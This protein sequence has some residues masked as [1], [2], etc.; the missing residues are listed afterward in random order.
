LTPFLCSPVTDQILVVEA[1]LHHKTC[2][3]LAERVSLRL[4]IG[5]MKKKKAG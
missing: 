1:Y 4:A 5:S 2:D 3:T